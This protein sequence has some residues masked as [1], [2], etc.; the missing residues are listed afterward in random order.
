MLKRFPTALS[1]L[2][3]AVVLLIPVLLP[4]QKTDADLVRETFANYK[5]AALAGN[6]TEAFR[7]VDNDTKEYYKQVLKSAIYSD[8]TSVQSMAL[9]DRITVLSVRHILPESDVIAQ[10]GSDQFFA[11]MIDKG[12]IAKSNVIGMEIGEISVEGDK[13]SGQ[14]LA[15]GRALPVSF[16]FQKES[17]LSKLD[18]TSLFATSSAGLKMFISSNGWTE[19]QFIFTSLETISGKPVGNSV[20]QPL[21]R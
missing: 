20:W 10:E 2:I 4:A 16:Q 19:N 13:A 11:F 5:K 14:M 3:L 15:G 7:W 6:G 9:I 17:G 21:K 8:S 18:L 12:L 1:V